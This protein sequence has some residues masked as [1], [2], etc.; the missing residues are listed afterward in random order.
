MK[1]Q[2]LFFMMCVSMIF[3]SIH[4]MLITTQR[5]SNNFFN[6]QKRNNSKPFNISVGKGSITFDV[7]EGYTSRDLPKI[8]D[9]IKKLGAIKCAH[10]SFTNPNSI[11]RNIFFCESDKCC[12]A[13]FF[14]AMQKNVAAQQ[15]SYAIKDRFLKTVDSC[16]ISDG[17]EIIPIKDGRHVYLQNIE[18]TYRQLIKYRVILHEFCSNIR[19]EKRLELYDMIKN[20][21]I[22]LF[23]QAQ[24][25]IEDGFECWKQDHFKVTTQ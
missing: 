22:C 14:L 5:I 18:S 25:I 15:R 13:A 21:N 11:G 2:N 4:P 8:Y 7:N 9:N 23:N 12:G 20:I 3:V 16:F 10:K 19:W 17:S 6:V 1:V 24:V